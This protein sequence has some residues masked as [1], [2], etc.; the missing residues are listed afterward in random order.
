[1]KKYLILIV[2]AIVFLTS[3][4][5]NNEPKI[6]NLSIA[7]DDNENI[8][9]EIEL[10][11]KRIEKRSKGKIKIKV[12]TNGKLPI[13]EDS[14]EELM[15]NE[16]LIVVENPMY[17]KEYIPEYEGLL[18]PMLY[19]NQK[20]YLDIIKS[21]FGK[22]VVNLS[23]KKNIKVLSLNY[24]YEFR[25]IIS[26]KEIKK[27][28]DLNELNIR[29]PGDALWIETLG[30][31]GTYPS[32][33]SF[34]EVYD[35]LKS[36]EIEGLDGSIST[37]YKTRIYEVAK[38]LSLTKHI[39]KTIGVFIPIELWNNFSL[40]EQKI[41][42]DEFEK[43]A[44]NN[45][46]NLKMLENEQINKLKSKGVKFNNIDYND[47]SNKIDEFYIKNKENNVKNIYFKIK[48]KLIKERK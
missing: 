14:F 16:N 12:F 37:M 23:E 27:T 39:I 35:A 48:E 43:G 36:K 24:I 5:R 6:I 44:I 34:S 40:S 32:P 47:F 30:S 1:M 13:H 2:I 41:I 33:L 38:N 25:N 31:F 42:K 17:L 19:K 9:K 11:S 10:V 46:L 45:N 8:T 21:S 18:G 26:N 20:E 7:F 3:C 4:N 22:K 15:L 28:K 29:I